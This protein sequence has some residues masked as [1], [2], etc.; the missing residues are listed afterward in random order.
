M[1][2][3]KMLKALFS[4]APRFAPADC[5]AR[6]KSGE[7]VLVDVREASEW[8]G[9]VARSA[10]LLPFSDLTGER[11]LWTAFLRAN[12]GRDLLLYCASGGRSGMA[13]RIL[14]QEKF[15]VANTG[16]FSDWQSAGWPVAHPSPTGTEKA[17]RTRGPAA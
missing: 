6:I 4:S 16:G 3:L 9:G 17:G 2:F 7:A 10:A 5:F 12:A 14:A 13:A 11:R 8:S 15:S 1:S